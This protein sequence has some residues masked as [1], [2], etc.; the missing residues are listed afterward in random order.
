MGGNDAAAKIAVWWDMFDCPVP[1]GIEARRVRP[2]LE[3]AFN[4]LGYT[5]PVSITAYGDQKQTPEH[6][7]LRALSSTGV[8]VV[9]TRS[10]CT[11]A[12]MYK[13]M[14]KWREDNP[15]PAKMMIISN[16]VLDVFNWDLSRLQQRTCYDLFLAYSVEPRAALFVCTRKEWLWEKLLTKTS[17]AK[18]YCKSCSLDRQSLKSFRKH[19]STKKHALEEIL[20][21][22][23]SQLQSVTSKWGKNYAATPEFATAKI[24]VLWDLFDCPIPDGYDARRIR[25]SLEG[26]FKEL[27]YSGP[28]SITAYGDQNKPLNTSS[29]ELYLPLESLWYIPDLVRCTCAVMYKDMVKWREDNP[30]PAKM[31][32][33]SNQVLDVFNWDLSRLQQRTCYDLFLAYSV[34]PRAALFVCTRKEWLWEKL[35]TKTSTA[36]KWGKNYAATPEFA[37]AKI[38]VLWDLFDCPIPDGYDARRIRPSLEGAF[39]ELGYS[40]PVSITAYGDHKQTPQHHLQALSSTGI[41]VAHATLEV[42]NGRI[43]DDIDEWQYNNPTPATMMI[44]SDEADDAFSDFLPH[45]LQSNKYNLFLAYSFRPREMSVLV[46]SAEWLWD[47][48]LTEASFSREQAVLESSLVEEL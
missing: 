44:I 48:L 18:F 27:G 29:Y 9:H 20:R 4:E 38:H 33:I 37:T 41:D 34:E 11:C 1:E 30:P 24:H 21:P 5:G 19:L 36:N 8:A 14:V 42:V 47:S 28:V 31:M 12:V 39:K 26:A 45:L 17:T 40:G 7:L 32:I 13:D 3:G 22:D 2:G 43:S 15:P 10:G 25:P 23:D 35:L 46:T 16:Q 6:L